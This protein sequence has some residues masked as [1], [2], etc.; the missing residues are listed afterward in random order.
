[1]KIERLN[2]RQ[3]RCTLT[4][5]D[6]SQ[7][8]LRLSE[9]AYGTKKARSLFQD[10][11]E[12]ARFEVGF[13]AEDYPLMIEAVP[14][15]AE[16][17]VL[18]VTQVDDPEELDTRFSVFGPSVDEA[19]EDDGSYEYEDRDPE[20]ENG[21]YRMLQGLQEGPDFSGIPEQ[22]AARLNPGGI[23]QASARQ[24]LP[25]PV[26]EKAKPVV[27]IYSFSSLHEVQHAAAAVSGNLLNIRNTLYRD[28][29]RHFYLCLHQKKTK[30]KDHSFLS[31]CALLAEYGAAAATGFLSEEFLKEHCEVVI[32]DQ[33]LQKLAL[34]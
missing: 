29:D 5:E 6:L 33:A 10:M 23:R 14:M 3:I 27:R 19:D 17:L 30:K 9:F 8:G 32:R 7:R 34:L 16:C 12:Q 18:I 1:M 21:F 22:F 15:G 2:D 11:M 25:K 20:E 24:H 28:G 4:R 31:L 13:E 26:E